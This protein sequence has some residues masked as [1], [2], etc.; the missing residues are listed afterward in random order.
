M[1]IKQKLDQCMPLGKYMGGLTKIYFGALSKQLE[2]LGVD[3]HFSTL[4][5]I[6]RAEQKCTQQ[7]LSDLLNCDKVSMVR[8]L[9]YLVSKKM[10]S[11]T[12]NPK[13]RRE[14]IIELSPKAKKIMPS[15]RNGVIEMNSIALKG[16]SKK[17]IATFYS[18]MAAILRNIEYLPAN[19]VDIKLK[20][21]K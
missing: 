11:R 5:A 4:L 16:I 17:D 14:H 2:P 21:K 18:C 6:D 3:R 15:I 20:K 10:I 1:A 7:Y 8:M 13:D 12:V 9:D 19:E